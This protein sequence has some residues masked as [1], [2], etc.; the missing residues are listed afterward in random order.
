MPKDL[1]VSVAMIA[2]NDAD[3][4]SGVVHGIVGTIASSEAYYEI[5][6]IDNGSTDGSTAI[7]ERLQK[8]IPNIRLLILSRKYDTEVAYAAALDNCIGDYVVLLEMAHDPPAMI[9]TLL[10]K[11]LEGFDV[12]IAER[13]DRSDD[14][15]VQRAFAQ[16]FYRVCGNVS[17]FH[18]SPNASYFRV[19]SRRA[20]NAITKIKH[21]KRY[22]KY[23]SALIGFTSTHLPY[24]RV[25]LRVGKKNRE[26]TWALIRRAIDVLIS[27]STLLLRIVSL[28]GVI[29]SLLNL[30]FIVYVF[31][32]SMIKTRTAEGWVSTSLVNS[33][34]FFLLFV[35]LTIMSE[36]IVRV[37]T[38]SKDQPLY[39]IAEER[40]STLLTTK[41]DRIN[42]T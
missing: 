14:T 30:L 9:P 17:G 34:M 23:L 21:K 12:V 22:L 7:V 37:L 28:L 11:A 29:A 19:L 3:I 4:I 16:L 32:V 2:E 26:G 40:N 39:F 27:N 35:I 24:E 5:L 6:I 18:F 13:R 1:L 42:V 15:L 31:A 8:E 20:V 38:E 10:Q 41:H 36:Y 25:P 33:T